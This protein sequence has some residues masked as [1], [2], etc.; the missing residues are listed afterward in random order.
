VWRPAF[1]AVVE[2]FVRGDYSLCE[3][4]D[5]VEPV[6]QDTAQHIR[7]YVAD[8]GETLVPLPPE[9]WETSCAQW[10]GSHWDVLVDLWTEAEGRSDMVLSARVT[11][12][13]GGHRIK[14][15]IVYV[16]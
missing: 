11:E 3:A 6:P 14:L 4:V 5:G 10:M 12:S 16:P 13:D 7:D 9:T 8:Y 2:A 15:G 1:H